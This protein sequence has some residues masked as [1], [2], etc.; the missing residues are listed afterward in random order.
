MATSSQRAWN[1]SDNP[2]FGQR[3]W[4]RPKLDTAQRED[5]VRRLGDGERSADL[6]AEFGVSGSTIRRLRQYVRPA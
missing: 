5:I 6:A 1:N 3:G 4:K 2:A